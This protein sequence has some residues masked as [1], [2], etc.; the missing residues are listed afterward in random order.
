M[1]IEEQLARS[2]RVS[3]DVRRRAR[4]RRKMRTDQEGFSLMERYVTFCYLR[5][6]RTDALYLPAL[7]D[8]ASLVSVLDEIVVTRLAVNG[9]QVSGRLFFL[10]IVHGFFLRRDRARADYTA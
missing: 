5:T 7:Q 10:L 6:A 3:F 1:P 4:E 2:G 8:Q 9:D